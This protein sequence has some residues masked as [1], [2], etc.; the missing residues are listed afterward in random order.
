MTIRNFQSENFKKKDFDKIYN[1][2]F[3]RKLLCPKYFALL[4]S[5]QQ[6]PILHLLPGMRIKQTTTSHSVIHFLKP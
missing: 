5:M 6:N 4:A 1:D 2:F 3:C